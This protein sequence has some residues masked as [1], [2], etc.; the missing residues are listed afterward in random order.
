M[1]LKARDRV[2]IQPLNARVYGTQMEVT[3]THV[4]PIKGSATGFNAKGEFVHFL[5]SEVVKIIAPPL[6]AWLKIQID[7]GW[8]RLQN[9]LDSRRAG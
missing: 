5:L 9:W 4:D 8:E 6:I 3:V 7:A 1:R 2:I